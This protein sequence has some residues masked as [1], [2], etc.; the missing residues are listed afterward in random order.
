MAGLFITVEGIDGAGKTTHL[1]WLVA[2]FKARNR[3]VVATREPGG[4]PLGE[5]LRR[6]LLDSEHPIHA[7]T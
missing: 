2:Y 7:E 6:L 4:T 3:P 1:E 5:A